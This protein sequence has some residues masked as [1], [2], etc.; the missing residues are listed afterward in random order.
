[1]G[2]AEFRK[3]ANRKA[4]NGQERKDLYTDKW[5]GDKYKGSPVNILSVLVV[6][7]VAV[8][9]IGLIIAYYTYGT[10]WG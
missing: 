3:N 6:V 10:V 2:H 8:P 5:D 1:M 4:N 7:S 9:L